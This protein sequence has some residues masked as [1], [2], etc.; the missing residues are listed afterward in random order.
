MLTQSVGT[1]ISITL[2]GNHC[3]DFHKPT[4][5]SISTFLSKI[6]NVLLDFPSVWEIRGIWSPNRKVSAVRIQLWTWHT[7]NAGL[8]LQGPGPDMSGGRS[9]RWQHWAQS[10]HMGVDWQFWGEQ[11]SLL[12]LTPSDT[13]D[14]SSL[15][16]SEKHQGQHGPESISI[17][18]YH[19]TATRAHP[20]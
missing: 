15:S 20:A 6:W 17:S 11:W 18:L 8:A 4:A 10:R 3:D 2:E 14:P 12:A 9:H 7:A 1:L 19:P 13:S 16:S 5:S